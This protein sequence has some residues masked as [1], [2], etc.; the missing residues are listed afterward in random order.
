MQTLWQDLRYGAR[1][2]MKR[3]GM[4]LAFGIG[5]NAALFSVVNALILRPLPYREPDRLAQLSQRDLPQG[6]ADIRVSNADF[7]AWRARARSFASLTAHNVHNPALDTGEGAVDVSGVFVA[8]NFFATLGATLQLGRA[9]TPEEEQPV[10]GTSGGAAAVVII[11]HQ[12]WQSRLGGRADV[13]GQ[14]ITL[15]ERPHTVVG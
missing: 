6:V 13:I 11:S 5:L 14:T 7:L 3:P 4:T 15:E 12:F 8:S 1:M 9:F 10:Q 2:L